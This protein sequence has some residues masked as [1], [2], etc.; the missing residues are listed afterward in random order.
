MTSTTVPY[1]RASIDGRY[2]AIVIGSGIGGL[3][4][5]ALLARE[6][7]RRVLVLERHYTP[8]GYT[9]AFRRPGYEWDVGVH[10]IGQMGAHSMLRRAFDAIAPG[11][12][13]ADMGDVYDTIV[14]DGDR[15]D[16]VKGRTRWRDRMVEYF[17]SEAEAIDAYLAKVREATGVAMRL[18]GEK[19]LPSA[20]AAVVGP[21]MRSGALR[22]TRR[23]VADVLDELTDD[24]RLKAVL[25]G[26]YGDYGLP[27]RQAS[28]FMHATVVNHYLGGAAYPVG[29][30]GRIAEAIIPIIEAAGGQVITSAEVAS[31]ELRRGAAVG[32]QMTDGRVIEAPKVISNAGALTT[33]ERLLPEEARPPAR[34]MKGLDP[35]VAHASLYLG[36]RGTTASLGL[37]KTNIWRYPHDDHDR[38]FAEYVADEDAPLPVA[39]LSFPSA[40]DPDFD[41]RYPGHS[42]VEVVTL[43]PWARY[44]RWEGTRWKKRGEDYET[45]KAR[46]TNRLLAELYAEHPQLEPHLDHCELSTPLSTRHFANFDRGEIYGLAHTPARFEQRWLRPASPVDNLYLTGS[47]VCTA[48]VGGALFGGYLTAS[49][50]LRRNL[51]GELGRR[52]TAGISAG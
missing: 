49:V 13:W 14:V 46:L 52:S 44:A 51:I 41:R 35:S 1:K 39:Y 45:A 9:H 26:Q 25:C 34:R 36:F 48:G 32:V 27:P 22:I 15:Y 24:P 16:F 33:F 3:A 47:D 21:A 38:A 31:I 7:G 17:P 4:T 37:S 28:F 40:K 42:T 5:A 2:D 8:G 29:G 50:L 18:F 12:E 23:T 6:A 19:G 30:A 10:Y 20:L 43:A 11:L